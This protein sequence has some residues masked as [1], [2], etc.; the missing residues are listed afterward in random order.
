MT[1]RVRGGPQQAD[2]L[3]APTTKTPWTDDF[4]V[5]YET[6]LGEGRSVMALFTKRPTRDIIEDYDMALYAFRADGSTTYPG[7]TDHPESLF[8]GLDYFGYNEFPESNFVIATLAGGARDYQGLELTFRQRLRSNWQALAAYTYGDATGNTN[9]DSNA[10]FQATC[11]GS[12]RA[13]RTNRATSPAPSRTC[14]R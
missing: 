10:D 13:R 5:S 11:S 2:A 14:S 6:E 3:F 12:I 7:P 1:Y 9:S 8:L 4:Q